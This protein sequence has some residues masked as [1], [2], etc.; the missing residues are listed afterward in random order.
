MKWVEGKFNISVSNCSRLNIF[1]PYPTFLF[2]QES[3]KTQARENC[4]SF[5]IKFPFTFPCLLVI[6]FSCIVDDEAAKPPTL[7]HAATILE[8]LKLFR[9]LSGEHLTETVKDVRVKSENFHIPFLRFHRRQS[10][11]STI[12]FL[13]N[14]LVVS[15][16]SSAATSNAPHSFTFCRYADCATLF[17]RSLVQRNVITYIT[18]ERTA[19]NCE[20]SESCI[21]RILL[22]AF[23]LSSISRHIKISRQFESRREKRARKLFHQHKDA[24]HLVIIFC[25]PTLLLLQLKN[26]K[27]RDEVSRSLILHSDWWHI[28]LLCWAAVAF[29]LAWRRKH[30][31]GRAALELTEITGI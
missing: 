9:Q 3:H 12:L 25:P 13:S 10:W 23:F 20:L 22:L 14:F 26:E 21:K 17:L 11:Y 16:H 6:D 24:R 28:V 5:W 15:H 29:A 1:F 19:V 7:H 4:E 2:A 30:T 18:T 27:K 31:A 8:D